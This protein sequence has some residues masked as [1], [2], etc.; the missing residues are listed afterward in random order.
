M[1]RV[2]FGTGPKVGNKQAV[3]F[4]PLTP[5][6]GQWRDLDGNHVAYTTVE[7][8]EYY[9]TLGEQFLNQRGVRA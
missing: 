4:I 6:T 9:P 7:Q 8:V 2:F 3:Q 1:E 5:A